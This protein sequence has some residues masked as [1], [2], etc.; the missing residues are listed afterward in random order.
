M[1]IVNIQAA[2]HASLENVS[3]HVL[4]NIS[5]FNLNSNNHLIISCPTVESKGIVTNAMIQQ[6]RDD[7]PTM[8]VYVIRG[9]E[10]DSIRC[11]PQEAVQAVMCEDNQNAM[12]ETP[13]GALQQTGRVE[14]V[15]IPEEV[16]GAEDLDNVTELGFHFRN[17]QEEGST[18]SV[19][20]ESLNVVDAYN[21]P[22]IIASGMSSDLSSKAK[23][24]LEEVEIHNKIMT[25][26]IE[27]AK[28]ID[29]LRAPI[30]DHPDIKSIVK[31]SIELITGD[32]KIDN[33]LFTPKLIIVKT[34][35]LVTSDK[36]DGTKRIIGKMEFRISLAAFIGEQHND[37]SVLIR[38]CDRELVYR[39]GAGYHCGHAPI[40]G[41][42]CW[43]N[44]WEPVY[45]SFVNVDLHLLVDILVR[46]VTNPNIDDIWGSHM[47]HWPSAEEVPSES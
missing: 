35:E 31:Q 13:T 46:F 1:Y 18:N 10:Y 23:L 14:A 33:I 20:N 3:E 16:E 36:I 43:G 17:V 5:S 12:Q 38:N 39:S 29:K 6:L 25:Q 40:N 19:F 8:N 27:S 44:A 32:N 7:N 21:A 4:N 28:K 26:L 2:L 9:A 42:I 24:L 30:E 15:N 45:D 11:E 34:K 37:S 22:E 47:C 41:K